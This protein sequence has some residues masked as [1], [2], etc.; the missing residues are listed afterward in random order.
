VVPVQH[1]GVMLTKSRLFGCQRVAA[2]ANQLAQ[3]SIHTAQ[4]ILDEIKAERVAT[5]NVDFLRAQ[6]FLLAD[7]PFAARQALLEEVRHFPDS[8]DARELLTRLDSNLDAALKLPDDIAAAEPVFA[9]CYEGVRHHSML[10]W[11]RLLQ[12]YK[13]VEHICEQ[14]IHGDIVECGSAGGGS[15]ILMALALRHCGDETSRRIFACDTFNGMPPPAGAVDSKLDDSLQPASA[16][17]WA[18]GTCSSPPRHIHELCDAFGVTV[19]PIVGLFEDTLPTLPATKIALLHIDADWYESTKTVMM[20][21]FP[22]VGAGGI[23][24]IDDYEYWSGC[25]RAVDEHLSDTLKG[26]L[27]RIDGNAVLLRL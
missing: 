24:Q 8:V 22:R 10:T 7:D 3:G 21:A 26:K 4:S 20:H 23:V 15:A 5:R 16:S 19:Q 17:H 2:A 13:S 27:S 6:A 18:T 9:L 11:P 25:R 14:G 12:L 1:L